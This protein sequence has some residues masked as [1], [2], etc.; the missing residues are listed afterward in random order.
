MLIVGNH[1]LFAHAEMFEDILQDLIS[2]DF[3]YDV[4]EMEDALT[5]I[6]GDEIAREL[7]GKTFLYTMD[8]FKSMGQSFIVTC[9]ADNDIIRLEGRELSRFQKL[10]T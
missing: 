9:V 5:E 7:L 10:L 3:A 1:H 2:S 6:L 4:A 8:G